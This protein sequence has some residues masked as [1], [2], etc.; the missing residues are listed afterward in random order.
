MG[1]IIFLVNISSVNIDY[2]KAFMNIKYRGPD[3]STFL[4]LCTNN[5]DNLNNQQ[6]ELVNYTLSKDQIR[7]YKQYNFVL[8]YHRNI[9]NDN[10][11]NAS[12]PFEDP[13][14]N[15]ILTY[16]ELQSRPDRKLICNGEIYNYE[17]LI[18]INSFSDKDI[19][20]ICDVEILMP[21]YIR[22][23][24]QDT[25]NEIDGE[26]SF[27]L[28]ENIDTFQ[29]DILNIFAARDYLGIKPLY[30]IKNTLDENTNVFFI[31]EIKG[32][33]IYII[34]NISYIINHVPPGTYWS[35][36][37]NSFIPYYS[38]SK[39]MD[40]ENCTISSTQPDNLLNVYNNIHKL[41]TDS[42]ISRINIKKDTP[43]GI[44]LSGGFDSSI[45]LSVLI[46]YLLEK[47][48][49]F[50]H[51]HVF[52]LG[53]TLGGN[54]DISYSSQLITFFELKY[55]ITIHYHRININNIELL[56]SDIDKIIYHL[57]TFDP[58]TVRESIPYY[59]LMKY[60]KE[61]TNVKILLSG[62]GINELTCSY[63]NL[64]LN[65][66]QFQEKSVSLLENMHKYNLLK[67]D[68]ISNIFSLEIR[69]PFLQ[70]V[71]VEYML[72]LHPNL[73][74]SG[75]YSNEKEPISK[76]I[77]RKSFECGVLGEDML[78][79]C[80]LWR[81]HSTDSITNFQLRLTNY[82]N[83]NLVTDN[84]FDISLNILLNEQNVNLSTIPKNK[85][86]MYY[87]LIFRKYYPSRDNLITEFY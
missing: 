1:G 67:S 56:A 73:K 81:E 33:P 23:G 84:L 79:D 5:L 63:S 71:F 20:S 18:A 37:T 54:I 83:N 40:L 15:K 32:L 42:I 48:F 55:N 26:F 61:N 78:P 12:Q 6:Q 68:R 62:S 69:Y 8:G 47:N 10:T 87:R 9:I 86:E 29:L 44:L 3:D 57:E 27:V 50:D 53:D 51:L 22:Y 30:Y 24:I 39:F 13:I 82:I 17:N 34:E 58:H 43:I 21:M 60:I 35:F 65:D 70:K 74:R 76:Y 41:I 45:L 11:F 46:K 66:T 16:P 7:N 38:L 80:I 31:S 36:Q 4:T 77:I 72:S 52:T 64:N 25:L 14:N 28:T 19:T 2:I 85:E 59:Y 75:I 49:D